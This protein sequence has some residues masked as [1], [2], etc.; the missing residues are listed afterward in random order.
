MN[1]NITIWN[2]ST[3]QTIT[4][5]GQTTTNAISITNFTKSTSSTTGALNV[6]GGVGIERDLYIGGN[7][8]IST[9][10]T[11]TIGNQSIFLS[12]VRKDSANKF[13]YNNPYNNYLLLECS[14]N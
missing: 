13:Y 5:R 7:L 12:L 2:N 6:S 1:K 10:S 3:L 11:L 14:C 9:G 4:D 8:N